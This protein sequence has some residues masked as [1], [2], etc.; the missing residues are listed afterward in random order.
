MA[1]RE[2]QFTVT[3]P[4]F[5]FTAAAQVTALPFREGI[6][7]STEVVIPDGV[8][9]LAQYAFQYAGV[10]VWPLPVGSFTTGNNEVVRRS[11]RGIP[12]GGQWAFR[13]V[14]FDTWDHTFQIRFLVNEFAAPPTP[15]VEP[16][17]VE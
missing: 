4:A 6:V 1:D 5:T 16:V 3:V 11:F 10:Q 12:T 9:G 15:L 17:T 13:A 8:C 2:H 7:E 14:N